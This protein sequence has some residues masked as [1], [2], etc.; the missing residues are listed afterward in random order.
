MY[1]LSNA[2]TKHNW[3]RGVARFYGGLLP[4]KLR[5]TSPEDFSKSVKSL[6]V[7]WPRRAGYLNFY[8]F[9]YNVHF[10]EIF[11]IEANYACLLIFLSELLAVYYPGGFKSMRGCFGEMEN[12]NI[13]VGSVTQRNS[14]V[15]YF[16]WSIQSCFREVLLLKMVSKSLLELL[17]LMI[18]ASTKQHMWKEFLRK[19]RKLKWFHFSK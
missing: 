18:S 19:K 4:V 6:G 11:C 1:T 9:P 2:N 14:V 5:R 15:P 10:Q 13:R 7:S 17:L 12:C 8:I 16:R 3:W